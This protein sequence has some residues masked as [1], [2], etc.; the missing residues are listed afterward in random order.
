MTQEANDNLKGWDGVRCGR[1]GHEGGNIHILIA[2][3]F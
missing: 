3:S 2:D 1:E